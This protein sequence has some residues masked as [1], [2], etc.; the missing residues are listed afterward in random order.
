[1]NTWRDAAERPRQPVPPLG[2]LLILVRGLPLALV[3]YAGLALLALVRLFEAPLARPARPVTPRITQAV[4]RMAL[5][6]IGIRWRVQGRPMRRQGA[7]VS[8]HASWL[9]IFVLNAA[10]PIYFV[11]KAEVAAWPGIGLLARATGTV[12]IERDRRQAKAQQAMLA[13]RLRAGHR[14]LFFPEGT[15][16]DGLRVLP[17]KATLFEAFL[18]EGLADNLWV[19]PVSVAY[20]APPGADT[21]LYGWWGDM[22]FAPHFLR[23]LACPGRGEVDV[24]FHEPLAVRAFAGRKDLARACEVAVREGLARHLGPVVA[25]D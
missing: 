24:I 6:L 21:R 13:G 18:G 16:T 25:G 1:M 10:G 20:R 23:V 9:D 8:N 5:A 15:S 19:Q 4:C 14:L 12:F 3:V 22:D 11:S 7:L 17:F 2:W